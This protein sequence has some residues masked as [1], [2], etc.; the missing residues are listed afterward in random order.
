MIVCHCK[1]ITDS[2]IRA[3]VRGGA[4]TMCD[5][6]RIWG[7]TNDCG[8]CKRAVEAVLERAVASERDIPEIHGSRELVAVAP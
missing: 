4:S 2:K 3:A 8:G 1:G 7:A 6:A 5:L